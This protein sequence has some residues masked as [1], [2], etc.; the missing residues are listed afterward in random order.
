MSGNLSCVFFT[1]TENFFNVVGALK[2]ISVNDGFMYVYQLL[3]ELQ[4]FEHK[5]TVGLSPLRLRFCG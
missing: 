3:I 2:Y 5:K 4:C 1:V